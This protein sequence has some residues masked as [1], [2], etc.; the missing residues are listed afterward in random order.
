MSPTGANAAATAEVSAGDT[1]SVAALTMSASV[2]ANAAAI[3]IADPT[4]DAADFDSIA[5]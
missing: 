4:A 1:L 5:L 2:S 3:P